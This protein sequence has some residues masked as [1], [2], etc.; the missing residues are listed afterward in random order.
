MTNDLAVVIENVSST[1]LSVSNV[2][3]GS[4]TSFTDF[5]VSQEAQSYTLTFNSS[6]T[7]SFTLGS[8]NDDVDDDDVM[9]YA[10]VQPLSVVTGVGLSGS[11]ATIRCA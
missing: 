8:I 11:T 3:A 7:F 6:D 9:F 1:G 10:T 4:G 2:A 5:G